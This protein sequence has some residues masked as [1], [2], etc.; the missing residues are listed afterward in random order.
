MAKDPRKMSAFESGMRGRETPKTK[1]AGGKGNGEAS[2]EPAQ[3]TAPEKADA[4]SSGMRGVEEDKRKVL[5]LTKTKSCAQDDSGS[6]KSSSRVAAAT[7]DPAAA[8]RRRAEDKTGQA[9]AN[10]SS[11]GEEIDLPADSDGHGQTMPSESARRRA[12]EAYTLGI[13][14]NNT[15]AAAAG[16]EPW[17]EEDETHINIRVP[18]ASLKKKP[19]LQGS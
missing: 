5:R 7:H 19:G 18:K 4:Y 16:E 11:N 13:P 12:E 9:A 2:A 14:G 15:E 17:A 10:A 8:P 3:D 6:G 1:R